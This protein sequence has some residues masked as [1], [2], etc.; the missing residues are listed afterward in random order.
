[1]AANRLKRAALLMAL[2]AASWSSVPAQSQQTPYRAFGSQPFW[3]LE[4]RG[5]QLLYDSGN[6]P[7]IVVPTPRREPRRNGYR[8]R[9]RGLIVT[10]QHR[11]CEEEDAVIYADT[12][13]V[14]AHGYTVRGCG[15][16]AI[17]G[18]IQEPGE[19]AA[20]EIFSALGTEPFWGV[21][22]ANDRI[23]YDPSEGED[24]S[25]PTPPRQATSDGYRWQARR[26][27][28]EVANRACSDGMSNNVYPAEV[29][30]F[31]NG[32]RLTGCGG[33]DFTQ[34]LS[35]TAW[36]IVNVNLNDVSGDAYRIEFT[37]DRISG[38]AGCNRFNGTYSRRDD[39]TIV[40]GALATTRMACPEP[41]ME[42]ERAVL[43]MF[44]LPVR[45][46]Y[47]VPGTITLGNELGGIMLTQVR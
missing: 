18:D 45:L 39:R 28:V 46:S 10:V 22:V 30:V 35:G 29:K 19:R 41:Q 16:A 34:S 36:Q 4:I 15:G 12:V 40:V 14:T 43:E 1:M 25:A 37:G 26:I 32:A 24:V 23:V 9:A 31:V 17:G 44:T 6:D 33:Y 7:E 21:T 20:P 3:F 38:R 2:A 8:Y 11:P 42:H 27:T 5:G 47:S 13:R